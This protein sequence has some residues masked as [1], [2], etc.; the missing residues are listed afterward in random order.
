MFTR[1][2]APGIG[3][4][5]NPFSSAESFGTSRCKIIAQGLVNA[6]KDKQP[7]EVWMDFILQNIQKNFLRPEAMY[8]NPNSKYPYY[9]PT[10][11]N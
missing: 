8:L 1:P 2:L 7:K 11:E 5:E 10:F 3:F 6:W 9:F 4:A